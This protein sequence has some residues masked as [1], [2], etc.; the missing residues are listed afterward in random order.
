MLPGMDTRRRLTGSLWRSL[1]DQ[2]HDGG[3]RGRSEVHL[4]KWDEAKK[5]IEERTTYLEDGSVRYEALALSPTDSLRPWVP[6]TVNVPMGNAVGNVEGGAILDSG[7]D[8]TVLPWRFVEPSSLRWEELSPAGRRDQ[9]LHRVLFEGLAHPWRRLDG[10]AVRWNKYLVTLRPAVMHPDS[11]FQDAVL[12]TD[13]FRS[14]KVDF[15]GWGDDPP[16]FTIT[17]RT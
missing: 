7:S 12:G 9:D 10:G 5:L 8:T 1:R 2:G 14:F 13:F 15:S 6:I 11:G 16:T 4:V 17:P 3:G